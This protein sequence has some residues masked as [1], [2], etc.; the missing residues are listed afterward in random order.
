MK[1]MLVTKSKMLDRA[2]NSMLVFKKPSLFNARGENWK[3]HRELA[4]PAFSDES[5][6]KIL[7]TQMRNITLNLTQ[8]W[9]E[10]KK[11]TEIDVSK[12]MKLFSFDV[13]T[14]AGFGVELKSVQKNDD[15]FVKLVDKNFNFILFQSIF[16]RA[17]ISIPLVFKKYWDVSKFFARFLTATKA[18]K[19]WRSF[20][21]KT[22]ESRRSE[23][24]E[25]GNKFNKNDLLSRLMVAVDD[26]YKQFDD[27]ELMANC[28]TFMS[29]GMVGNLRIS[30]LPFCRIPHPQHLLMLCTSWQCIQINKKK[31]K[32]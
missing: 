6:K 17:L 26:E 7:E 24:K 32:K 12:E 29:A 18:V 20:L 30:N 28:G 22:V 1:D 11:E 13:I 27:E 15:T 25:L 14:S 8:K 3:K 31:L 2:I 4:S 19:L 21:A 16:G 9:K 5:L 23:V 10:L